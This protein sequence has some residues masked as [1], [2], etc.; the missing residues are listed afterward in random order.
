MQ[1]SS[2]EC[3]NWLTHPHI[4][5]FFSP[6]TV[7]AGP[8]NSGKSSI[9]D[10]I[11]FAMTATLRRVESKGDRPMLVTEGREKGAVTLKCADVTISRN[12]ADGKLVA[13]RG[14]PLPDDAVKEAIPFLLAPAA[15]AAAD[16][17]VRRAL[18]LKAMRVDLSAAGIKKT[19]KDRGHPS[20]LLDV[21]P[22][23]QPI[24]K[25]VAISDRSASEARGAWRAIT[26][27]N[28]GSQKAEGWTRDVGEPAPDQA[29]IDRA[30]S[31]I[32]TAQ[33][34]VDTRQ[35]A[36]GALEERLS[37]LAK[38]AHART[39][40]IEQ[41]RTTPTRR[42]DCARA[43]A[44]LEV[45][46]GAFN[47]AR[48]ALTE[49]TS[50]LPAAGRMT[51]PH[52]DA[53]VLL[54]ERRLVPYLAPT[55]PSTP[56]EVAEANKAFDAAQRAVGEAENAVR[57]AEALLAE[58]T[59][60]GKLL[61]T[62]Q[63]GEQPDRFR[64]ELDSLTKQLTKDLGRLR[65]AQ[66]ERGRLTRLATEARQAT[67]QTTEAARS[68]AQV[69]AWTAISAALAPDGIPAELLVYGLSTFN[70]T[71]VWLAEQ[72]H[73]R[74]VAIGNDMTIRA[75]GRPYGLLSESEQWRVDA[76]LGAAI[77][78]HS[79]VRFL[80]LDRLDVLEPRHRRTAMSWMYALTR[81]GEIDTAILLGTMAK[82]PEVPD[83]VSVVWLGDEAQKNA[84]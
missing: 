31:D 15:F 33:A 12:I 4:K 84:A 1:I 46:D 71:L 10:A 79:E 66:D 60:A 41:A 17:D 35:R 56:E 34:D 9:A 22:D 75:G 61:A 28:Y 6:L 64:D 81:S 82:A 65:A 23:D 27:Q 39:A 5:C 21:L 50:R 11:S 45:A 20:E 7:V 54:R 29:A 62:V 83:D 52:C 26:G 70:E 32:A 30:S 67:Q 14:L 73:W 36:I 38:Q 47:Q 8:N 59:A 40:I 58:A 77:A 44:Q 76:V 25:W 19:L 49:I 72:N 24:E 51:C 55:H 3:V 18:L 53:G 43:R 13:P 2:L 80:I 42:A 57:Q 48:E 74:L 68:H 16:A 63:E 69:K 78:I 37:A